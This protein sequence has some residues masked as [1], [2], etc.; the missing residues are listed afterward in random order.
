MPAS[1]RVSLRDREERESNVRRALGAFITQPQE[2]TH[3]TNDTHDVNAS[4]DTDDTKGTN[5]TKETN[6]TIDVNET[7]YTRGTP[8]SN[9]VDGVSVT[10][11]TRV[12]KNTNNINDT[13]TTKDTHDARSTNN[14]RVTKATRDTRQA[15][16]TVDAPGAYGPYG[17]PAREDEPPA[18][19]ML[20]G[21]R[22]DPPIG[23]RKR[24]NYALSSETI[25]RIALAS[26]HAGVGKAELVDAV[27][28]AALRDILGD[29]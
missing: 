18:S 20:K 14:T 13:K 26:A 23:A 12:S 22:F 7:S 25:K 5:E 8:V 4:K 28:C 17:A 10:N 16:R 9:V 24:Q 3:V 2:T 6:G 19:F 1:K 15:R 11:V 27:L 29:E 21:R